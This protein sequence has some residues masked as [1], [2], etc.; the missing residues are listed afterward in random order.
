[1]DEEVDRNTLAKSFV[2]CTD[3]FPIDDK[4]VDVAQ[5]GFVTIIVT[6]SGSCWMV[7]HDK[8]R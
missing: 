2:E 8:E 1:V 7:G 6:E 5:G 3:I 4:I